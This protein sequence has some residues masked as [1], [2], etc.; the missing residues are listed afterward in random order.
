MPNVNASFNFRATKQSLVMSNEQ[1]SIPKKYKKPASK[2][3]KKTKQLT[4]P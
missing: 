3:V 1:V 4:M 2:V